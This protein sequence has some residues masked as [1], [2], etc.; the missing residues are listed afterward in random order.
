MKGF[1]TA[2]LMGMGATLTL[3]QP[4]NAAQTNGN[5]EVGALLEEWFGSEASDAV[6]LSALLEK[7]LA[8]AESLDFQDLIDRL[9]AL[10]FDE[11]ATEIQ[12][13]RDELN[14]Y[15]YSYVGVA[16]TVV[17][18]DNSMPSFWNLSALCQEMYGEGARL[19]RTSDI[20]YLLER[21]TLQWEGVERAV[22]KSSY[23]IPYRDGLYDT[24][25][26]APVDLDGLVIFDATSDRFVTKDADRAASPACSA[27]N[28]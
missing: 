11:L 24:L 28:Q 14:L 8:L 27:R 17:P 13:L 5:A 25:V 23:P 26:S 21:R 2:I 4:V 1:I 9:S 15:R 22:F 7:L 16:E 20:A 10:D 3:A 19:A 6:E 18:E 12:G